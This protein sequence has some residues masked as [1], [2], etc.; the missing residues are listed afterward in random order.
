MSYF[1]LGIALYTFSV[2]WIAVA[3]PWLD[4]QYKDAERW[5]KK[6]EELRKPK[7]RPEPKIGKFARFIFPIIRRAS[8]AL[9]SANLVSVQPMT[10]PLSSLKF[11]IDYRYGQP[12]ELRTVLDDIVDALISSETDPEWIADQIVREVFKDH[13]YSTYNPDYVP[14][15]LESAAV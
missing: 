4:A 3:V 2:F 10:A 13:P 9:I 7:P 14:D 6:Q 8:P 11:Y 5:R 1:L 12:E 15:D